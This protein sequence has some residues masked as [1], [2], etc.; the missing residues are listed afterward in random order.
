[1][2]NLRSIAWMVLILGLGS[3][4][5]IYWTAEAPPLNPLGYESF[6][7][8]KYIHGLELFGGKFTV[9]TAELTYWFKGLWQGKSLAVMVGLISL[10]FARLLWFLGVPQQPDH[11]S[12]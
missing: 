3:A 9:V 8:K 2:K 4:V 11:K 10:V 1:M 6:N 12:D 5:I 7:S